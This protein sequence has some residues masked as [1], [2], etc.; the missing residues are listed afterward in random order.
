M[1]NSSPRLA[2]MMKVEGGCP[3]KEKM[4]N[5]F[6]R[7]SQGGAGAVEADD[8][9]G[10]LLLLGTRL[11]RLGPRPILLIQDA[12][13]LPHGR[14]GQG[15]VQVH[16]AGPAAGIDRAQFGDAVQP[17]EVQ[18]GGVLDDEQDV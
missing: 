6:F 4:L 17:G 5:L 14:H 2:Q 11:A 15:G 18:G 16:A 13:D 8:P 1:W 10:A 7:G 3:T 9:R 12:E